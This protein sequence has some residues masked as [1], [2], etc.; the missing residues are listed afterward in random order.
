[1]NR[2]TPPRSPLLIT[3]IQLSLLILFIYYTFIGGQTAQGVFDHQWRLVTLWLSTTVFG[4]WLLWRLIRRQHL[5]QTPFD[6]PLLYFFFAW[7]L[8]LLFSLNPV[9]SR[10]STVFFVIYLFFFYLAVDLGRWSWYVELVFNALIAVSGLVWMLALLQLSWWYQDVI[11]AGLSQ[12][13]VPPRL[14]VLGNPNTM[15]NYIALILPLILYKL[16]YA[17]YRLTRILLSVWVV[18]LSAAILLTGSRGGLVGYGLAI[19]V[20]I[21]VQ[22]AHRSD[23]HKAE[24]GRVKPSGWRA[25]W[26]RLLA[27]GG[28]TGLI[29]LLIGGAL[30]SR[31]LDQGVSVRQQVMAGAIKTVTIHPVF[32]AG[33]GTLG[34]ALLRYQQP[35]DVLWSDAH[36]L[37]LTLV[38]E[39]GLLGAVGLGWLVWVSLKLLQSTWRMERAAWNM[40]GLACFAALVGFLAHNMVDSMFKFPLIMILVATLAGFW[41]SS[42]VTTATFTPTWPYPLT[43]VA[44]LLLIMNTMLGLNGIKNIKAYNEAVVAVGQQDWVSAWHFLNQADTLAPQMPFYQRQRGLVAG[45]LARERVEFQA[46]GI[47][48][49]ETALQQVDQLSLDHANL[50]CLYW[51]N[52]QWD[53]AIREMTR[54]HEAEPENLIYQLNLAHYLFE[55][56]QTQAARDRYAQLLLRQPAALQSSYWSQTEARSTTLPDIINIATQSLTTS[57]PNQVFTLAQLAYYQGDF[58]A[59]LQLHGQI[60][61]HP[62]ADPSLAHI[63]MARALIGLDRPADAERELQS[64]V[65]INPRLGNAYLHLSQIALREAR[66]PEAKRTSDLAVFLNKDAAADFQAALV[67]EAEGDLTVA[68]QKYETAFNSLVTPYDPTQTRY[69][70]EIARRRPLP[71]TYLPCII[72]LYPTNLLLNITQAEA[73]LLKQQGRIEDIEPLHNRLRQYEPSLKVDADTQL[74]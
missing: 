11:A 46:E 68:E 26:S 21:F 33:P 25:S 66:L 70:T 37:P 56:G 44:L 62:P 59:S 19:G 10:E 18:M 50:A 45:Y 28:A 13:G 41:V 16:V 22:I 51:Q 53:K 60:L 36:N 61:Q 32:G 49:Y 57:D 69:A 40:A 27:G 17:H 30:L 74:P 29:A 7:I 55:T 8:A 12:I 9:Y 73:A 71:I 35:L 42:Y 47:T 6:F 2:T 64:A 63:G 14:S 1:M 52:E 72:R 31:S 54:A 43:L 3:A 34:E 48:H 23:K 58:E 4:G 65:A 38:A 24:T 15:A 67:A 5:P 39:T 20:F